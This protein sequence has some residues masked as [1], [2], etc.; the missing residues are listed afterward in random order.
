MDFDKTKPY[1]TVVGHENAHYEQNGR[2][3]T[4]TG[5][6]VDV[7]ELTRNAKDLLIPT[8][9]VDSATAFLQQVLKAGPLSKAALFKVAGESN[10]QWAEVQKAAALMDVVKF[11]YQ[12]QETWKLREH[13]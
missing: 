9:E 5:Q 11:K 3:Y 4:A 12:T 10:Q 1:G 8:P 13:A 6:P 2:L 7:L